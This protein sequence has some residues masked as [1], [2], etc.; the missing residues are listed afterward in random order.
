MESGPSDHPIQKFALRAKEISDR[1]GVITGVSQ[2]QADMLIN[3]IAEAV[4]AYVNLWKATTEKDIQ[5]AAFGLR[6][7]LELFVWEMYCA[8]SKENAHRLQQDSAR[9]AVGMVRAIEAM[10]TNIEN[11]ASFEQSMANAR[12]AL[13][14]F[15]AVA[16]IEDT[17]SNFYSVSSAA[18]SIDPQLGSLYRSLNKFLSKLVHPTAMSIKVLWPPDLSGELTQ[19]LLILGTVLLEGVMQTGEGALRDVS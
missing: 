13:Q 15:A 14:S 5:Y 4:R 10:P 8:A 7:L 1:L 6:N 2:N 18:R 17:D 9:D 11:I 12:I 16:G 3:I 19:L